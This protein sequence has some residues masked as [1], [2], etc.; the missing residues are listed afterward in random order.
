MHRDN[1]FNAN[2]YL[3]RKMFVNFSKQ[4]DK[5][6]FG[7][8][9]LNEKHNAL[10][11]SGMIGH[12]TDHHIFKA[13][14][15]QLLKLFFNVMRIIILTI[16]KYDILMSSCNSQSS[17]KQKTEIPGPQPP[18]AEELR[19]QFFFFII[20]AR[21]IRSLDLY[22]ADSPLLDHIIFIIDNS[23]LH[24]HSRITFINKFNNRKIRFCLNRNMFFCK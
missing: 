17:V 10:G 9:S 16:H 1:G 2:P 19:I 5:A 24:S 12:T 14:K 4:F 7:F 20:T 13:D 18:V 22:M 6:F 3:V 21:Y 15:R 11:A 23:Q 8:F